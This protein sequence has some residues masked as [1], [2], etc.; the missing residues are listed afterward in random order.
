MSDSR[1]LEGDPRADENRFLFTDLTPFVQ[2]A[3]QEFALLV[4]LIE[5]GRRGDALAVARQ[6]CI[7]SEMMLEKLEAPKLPAVDVERSPDVTDRC[8]RTYRHSAQS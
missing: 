7:R 3:Q 2:G 4:E 1:Y 5:A 8:G 6:C